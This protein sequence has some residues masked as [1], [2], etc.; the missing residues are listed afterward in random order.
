[1]TRN[2]RLEFCYKFYDLRKF[3]LKK[4]DL[5]SFPFSEFS[6][7]NQSTQ[8]NRNWI[9]LPIYFNHIWTALKFIL[10]RIYLNWNRFQFRLRKS[11]NRVNRNI[12]GGSIK[13][14]DDENIGK[15]IS[16][17]LIKIIL[18]PSNIIGITHSQTHTQVRDKI[19]NCVC[20]FDY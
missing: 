18:Y 15:E 10:L 17:E 19:E 14:D 12:L 16:P 9:Y 8:W 11:K 6:L 3:N 5:F 1:M 4:I 20:V 13:R 7:S 2:I